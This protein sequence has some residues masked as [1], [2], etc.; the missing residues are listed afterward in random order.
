MMPDMDGPATLHALRALPA[1]ARTPV[2]F[3][4]AQKR[5]LPPYNLHD[6]HVLGLIEKPFQPRQLL[7]QIAELWG[8]QPPEIADELDQERLAAIRHHYV[9]SLP[10]RMERMEALWA[11]RN[12]LSLAALEQQAHQ[13]SGTGA[14]LGLDQ[15]S[16][17][18]QRLEE[19][20]ATHCLGDGGGPMLGEALPAEAV[21]HIGSALDAF[22][23]A[24][25]DSLVGVG[26]AAE[27]GS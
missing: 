4:T 21:T 18:A 26:A 12:S 22:R 19:L 5:R 3:I 15:L 17:A 7:A 11:T 9:T 1:L 10:G 6:A 27:N 20:I 16:A 25:H 23:R 8:L 14:T 13:V 24:L 2:V